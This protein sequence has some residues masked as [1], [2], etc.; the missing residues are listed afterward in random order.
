MFVLTRRHQENLNRN[1]HIALLK[2]VSMHFSVFV[3]SMDHQTLYMYLF[4]ERVP[5][6]RLC[7]I[8]RFDQVG[9]S[10]ITDQRSYCVAYC[11][12][13]CHVSYPLDIPKNSLFINHNLGGTYFEC[14]IE[15]ISYMRWTSYDSKALSMH[16]LASQVWNVRPLE[17]VQPL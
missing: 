11:F 3:S 9:N 13:C 12:I 16:I 4:L 5:V 8:L 6:L 10:R 17:S 7:T 15:F 1:R 2:N 14:L